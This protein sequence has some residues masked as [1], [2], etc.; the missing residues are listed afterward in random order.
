MLEKQENIIY[1][2]IFKILL[3][4]DRREGREREREVNI[5]MGEKQR[6]GGCI[7][8]FG[9]LSYVPQQG[10]RPAALPGN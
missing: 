8:G 9:C 4:L 3:I 6:L 1:L 10:T 2:F 5:D 7:S